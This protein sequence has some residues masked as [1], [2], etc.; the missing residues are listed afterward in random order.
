MLTG[1]ELLTIGSHDPRLGEPKARGNPSSPMTSKE[2]TEC[3]S[4]GLEDLLYYPTR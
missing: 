1:N 2:L 4:P 3:R